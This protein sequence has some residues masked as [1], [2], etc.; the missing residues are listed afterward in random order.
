MIAEYDLVA[1]THDLDAAG[2]V[3]GDTGV[4]VMIHGDGAAFEV[5]FMTGSG[6]TL[7]VETL[8]RSAIRPLDRGEIRHARALAA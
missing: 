2:L 4:V 1:L 7:A 6:E 8:G 5:E 3:T